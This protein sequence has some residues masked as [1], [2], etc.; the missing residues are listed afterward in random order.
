[1]SKIKLVKNGANW[2]PKISTK[3]HW[4]KKDLYLCCGC[5]KDSGLPIYVMNKDMF[6]SET[7]LD[8]QYPKSRYV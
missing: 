5:N 1:M 4:G 6:C 2:F 7:C 3:D 8:K